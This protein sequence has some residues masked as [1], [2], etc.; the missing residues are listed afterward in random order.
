MVKVF[1][2]FKTVIGFLINGEAFKS[3]TLF[4]NLDETY[5]SVEGHTLSFFLSLSL[6][7]SLSLSLSLHERI[8]RVLSEGVQIGYF[9]YIFLVDGG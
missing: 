8:K 6:T 5:N 1:N 2:L 9:F 3:V 4:S 7:L